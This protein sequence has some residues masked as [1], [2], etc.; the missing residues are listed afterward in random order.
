MATKATQTET[1]DNSEK[2]SWLDFVDTATNTF[3]KVWSAVTP[4]RNKEAEE[5]NAAT[6][7]Q[8]TALGSILAYVAVGIAALVGIF[9][10]IRAFK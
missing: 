5:I 7:R 8:V 9:L 6:N 4:D 10:I 3:G 1:G 2:P